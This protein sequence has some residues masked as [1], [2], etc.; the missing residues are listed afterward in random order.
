VAV[1]DGSLMRNVNKTA[2]RLWTDRSFDEDGESVAR[3][4]LDAVAKDPNRQTRPGRHGL[5][6]AIRRRLN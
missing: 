1:T 3:H 6:V 5:L 2:V 4:P